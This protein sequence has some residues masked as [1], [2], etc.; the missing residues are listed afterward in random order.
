MVPTREEK[1]Y[2]KNDLKGASL[3]GSDRAKPLRGHD[4]S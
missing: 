4:P 2:I 3:T 1:T